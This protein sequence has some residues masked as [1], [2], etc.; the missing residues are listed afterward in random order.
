MRELGMGGGGIHRE[1]LATR[2]CEG[3][4]QETKVSEGAEKKRRN[5]E[6]THSSRSDFLLRL[7]LG[8]SSLGVAE[9][10]RNRGKR[11]RGCSGDGELSSQR[12]LY[13]R[14]RS[15]DEKVSEPFSRSRERKRRRN[16]PE[17]KRHRRI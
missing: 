13:L 6:E 1:K 17:K 4:E 14:E 5:S 15:E 8:V 12:G 2:F 3:G 11:S 9:S 10:G 7:D 16:V